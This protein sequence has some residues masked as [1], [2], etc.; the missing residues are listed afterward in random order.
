MKTGTALFLEFGFVYCVDDILI[1]L[2]WQEYFDTRI[3]VG[4]E[5]IVFSL[6]EYRF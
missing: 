5:A 6:L 4:F 3:V 1:A 2:N